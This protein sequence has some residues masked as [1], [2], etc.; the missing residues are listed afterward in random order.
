MSLKEVLDRAASIIR[1]GV[2]QYEENCKQVIIEPILY[3]LGWDQQCLSQVVREYAPNPIQP[4]EGVDYALIVESEPCVFIEAK[5]LH[6]LNN[7]ARNQV[8]WYGNLY[9]PKSRV[10]MLVLTDSQIWEFY[11]DIGVEKPDYQQFH[12]IQIETTGTDNTTIGRQQQIEELKLFLSRTSLESGSA[13]EEAKKR[14]KH[15]QSRKEIKHTTDSTINL[16]NGSKSSNIYGYYFKGVYYPA[17]SGVKLMKGVLRNF[18]NSEKGFLNRLHVYES[19]PNEVLT[20]SKNKEQ[21]P[22]TASR[23]MNTRIIELQDGWFLFHDLLKQDMRNKIE[24][25]CEVANV[26]FGDRETGLVLEPEGWGRE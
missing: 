4:N 21:F 26:K 19:Q 1:S 17:K 8:I 24:L 13:F 20:V 9:S 10:P 25:Y 15:F 6:K 23:K 12:T 18:E 5:M 14:L 7:R 2:L 16:K 22:E 3:E 11:I